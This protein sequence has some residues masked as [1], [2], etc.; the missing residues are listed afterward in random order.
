[1]K[2]VCLRPPSLD[3]TS[4]KWSIDQEVAQAV[5]TIKSRMD[6]I[7]TNAYIHPP[8]THEGFYLLSRVE[9]FLKLQAT[10]K[11]NL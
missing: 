10:K 1:M 4:D 3:E 7:W 9:Y 6:H 11:P 8:H 2:C 5:Y